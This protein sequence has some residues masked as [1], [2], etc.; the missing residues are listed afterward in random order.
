MARARILK[1]NRKNA[2][3][4]G[5][6]EWN[7]IAVKFS[8]TIEVLPA[9]EFKG[10][11]S[12]SDASSSDFHE[13]ITSSSD[14]ETIATSDEDDA[15]Y[16]QLFLSAFSCDPSLL[17][18]VKEMRLPQW[19]LLFL[20]KDLLDDKVKEGKCV[21]MFVCVCPISLASQTTPPAAFSSFILEMK[22]VVSVWV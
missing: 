6:G 14:A 19:T 4:L 17:K 10:V 12:D 2:F 18:K 1:F 3:V 8:E 22:R 21:T 11:G 13:I 15:I 20:D 16:L 9:E 5:I 7:N